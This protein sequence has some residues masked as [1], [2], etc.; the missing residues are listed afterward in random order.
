[1]DSLFKILAVLAVFNGAV[2]L[3]LNVLFN[4]WLRK[5]EPALWDQLGR[6]GVLCLCYG[7]RLRFVWRRQYRDMAQIQTI[8]MCELLR[9]FLIAYATLAVFFAGR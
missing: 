5:F 3:A 7:R 9:G 1:M 6:P 8:A 4:S 2:G